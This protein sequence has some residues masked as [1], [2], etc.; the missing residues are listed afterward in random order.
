MSE[1][2]NAELLARAATR[3]EKAWE[4]IVDRFSGL[5]WSIVRGYR[6]GPA[7]EA[8]VFQTVWLRLA[9][10]VERIR[11]PDRLAGWLARTAKNEAV[12]IVRQRQR[13]TPS[14]DVG[15]SLSIDGDHDRSILRSES[16]EAVAS[17]LARLS[18]QCQELLRLLVAD[19]AVSYAEISE[20]V[21]VA[22]GSIGP[23]RARCLD[24][25]RNT[26]EV[27]RITQTG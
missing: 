4:A 15:D 14:E 23:T 18:P 16:D 8:D 13:T 26:P 12:A 6:L 19:P 22:V 10:N 11:E 21:G 25:L 3:D 1:P 24:R 20:I 2:S 17:G 27:S 9:E 5:V 7:A